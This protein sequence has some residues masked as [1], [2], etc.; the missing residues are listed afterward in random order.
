MLKYISTTTKT[1]R[2]RGKN[3][4]SERDLSIA[5]KICLK[6]PT[7][8]ATILRVRK[9]GRTPRSATEQH[10]SELRGRKV[11]S[12][13][14]TMRNSATRQQETEE[15]AER[16][17]ASASS[18]M[19]K[20]GRD[21]EHITRRDGGKGTAIT[22]AFPRAP[23]HLPP[24]RAEQNFLAAIARPRSSRA[25]LPRNGAHGRFSKC[26]RRGA[27]LHDGSQA[28]DR[29]QATNRSWAAPRE[30]GSVICTEPNT[31]LYD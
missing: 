2:E 31:P 7:N 28:L 27:K 23:P 16:K 5:Y 13:A 10:G 20:R 12:P 4:R 15:K 9:R 22:L 11:C 30:P 25:W 1:E 17:R 26:R 19:G 29:V 21:G 8:R 3:T 14:T 18:R 24:A 6:T